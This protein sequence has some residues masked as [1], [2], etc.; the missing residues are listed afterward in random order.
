M[1]D[2]RGK[3]F[4]KLNIID[5]L[6]ILLLIVAVALIGWKVTRKDGASNASRTILTYTV[7]VEGVDQEV[8]EGIKAYVPG[9][10]GIGDQLMAN[11]EMVDAYVTNVTAAPHEGG[12]TM[13]DVNG[14]TMTF[15][16]E[17]DDT[18]DLTFTIQANVVNSV[19]NEVGTQE[20]RIGKSHIVKTVHFELN[21]GTIT[22]C[23][24]EPWAEG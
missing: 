18:L 4:G 19:T 22:T 7:E 8:Y 23:E 11:G 9:E 3:L 20:V 13:T 1:V 21:N 24:T 14:T 6:V 16:V 2:E 10:S 12:L 17:G 15:P 5:L